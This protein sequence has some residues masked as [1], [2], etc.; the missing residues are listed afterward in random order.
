MEA[1]RRLAVRVA[2]RVSDRL[3][4][5]V[6]VNGVDHV[7]SASIGISYATLAPGERAGTV[8]AEQVLQD[9]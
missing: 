7:V 5:P 4:D 1:D 2:E 6:T 8:T 9:C 3:Q